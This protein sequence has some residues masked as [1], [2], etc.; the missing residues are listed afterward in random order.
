[1]DKHGREV[2][3]ELKALGYAVKMGEKSLSALAIVVGAAVMREG[4]EAVLFLYGIIASDHTSSH[5]A[6]AS[7]GITGT[8]AGVAVGAGLYYGLV[9]I[10]L[11][12][13]FRVTGV[14]ILLLAAGLASQAAS[15]LIQADLLPALG[16]TVW[17]TSRL[18]SDEGIVGRL[19][20]T[21]IGYTAR[22][23][24]MQLVFYGAAILSILGIGAL[25]KQSETL[26]RRTPS[27]NG[28]APR[29]S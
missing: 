24:G 9:A 3:R 23:S 25:V 13:L 2:S 12:H 27:M 15:F 29:R 22:P 8:L 21:L 6:L 11:R 28:M 17:N 20:H 7:G 16:D 5:L 10:P 1:M 4:S 18:I 26:R 19:L 14:L